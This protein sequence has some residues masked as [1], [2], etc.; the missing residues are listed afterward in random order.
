MLLCGI[1]H[2]S[3]EPRCQR[4]KI[5]TTTLQPFS[6][7]NE[8]YKESLA[9]ND[10]DGLYL[11]VLVVDKSCLFAY[12]SFL[13]PP[14]LSLAT[15]LFATMS[16]TFAASSSSPSSKLAG[17]FSPTNVRSTPPERK[18]ANEGRT[19]GI[20]ESRHNKCLL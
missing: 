19:R 2:Y 18:R 5:T 7:V 3:E 8:L 11:A 1:S 13:S 15:R 17:D 20:R 4:V 14:L 16:L 12:Y 10:N 9:A 6:M